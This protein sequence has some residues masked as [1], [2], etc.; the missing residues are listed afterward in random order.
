MAC[1][2]RLMSVSSYS[3]RV[4]LG[5]APLLAAAQSRKQEGDPYWDRVYSSPRRIF[6]LRPNQL[7]VS[8]IGERK[9]GKA[10]DI[11]MG[12][13]RNAVFLA[14]QG[15][16]VTGFDPS[17]EGIRQAKAEAQKLGVKLNALVARDETFDYGKEAW[18]LIL[19]TYV[20]QVKPDDA[21]RF[22]AA[23]KMSGIF[24]YEN[25]NPGPRNEL[26]KSFLSYRILRYEDVEA[27]SDW[28][29]DQKQRVER[30]VAEKS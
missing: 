4:F 29:P 23:L 15:W 10:L 18:D 28:H 7:L 2:N 9:P 22:R 30:L 25:N 6:A 16:D 20:R 17:A 13:G 26:L 12:Q 5:A 3:R 8:A 14:K 19:M 24:V 1:H 11:G 27:N 21:N